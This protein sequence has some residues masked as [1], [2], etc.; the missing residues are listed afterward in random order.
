M[1]VTDGR[2]IKK[3][4]RH[5]IDAFELWCWRRLLS[6][7]D[8]KEI[9]SVNAKG[10][11]SWI[12]IRRTD[13][14]GEAP[15]L[16]P[17]DAKNWLIGKD[18]DAGKDWRQEEKGT[19]VDEMVGWHHRLNGHGFMQTLGDGEGQGNL[20]CYNLWGLK[21][22]DT[23]SCHKET[24]LSDW[25]TRQHSLWT[26]TFLDASWPLGGEG[27]GRGDLCNE[28][29]LRQLLDDG[30]RRRGGLEEPDNP[31]SECVL[32]IVT[33]STTHHPPSRH[34]PSIHPWEILGEKP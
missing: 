10:N 18:P 19:T 34:P 16:W 11:Q 31:L 9:K 20:A 27:R 12:F 29:L 23:K 2:T 32:G 15:I 22:L 8:F 14:E 1:P 17:P 21:E 33:Y 5:R 30:C 3:T 6:P 4:D 25:T 28:W 24:R 26:L 7:L 13:A